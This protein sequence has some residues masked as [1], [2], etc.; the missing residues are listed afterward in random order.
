MSSVVL[1]M[2]D[3]EELKI[4]YDTKTR[5]GLRVYHFTIL[6]VKS[7]LGWLVGCLLAC[8]RSHYEAYVGLAHIV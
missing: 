2:K 1:P 5:L 8:H 3:E 7:L 4:T 6:F